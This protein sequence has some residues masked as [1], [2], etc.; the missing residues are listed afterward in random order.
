MSGL[1]TTKML[2]PLGIWQKDKKPA[3]AGAAGGGAT[4][5]GSIDYAA[6]SAEASRLRRL[7][8]AKTDTILT[9]NS[10]LGG[11]L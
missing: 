9:N 6:E 3:A 2:D 7:R 8:M 4:G 5:G 1:S 10:G 11:V